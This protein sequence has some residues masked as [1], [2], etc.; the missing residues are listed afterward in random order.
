MSISC[1]LTAEAPPLFHALHRSYRFHLLK[2]PFFFFCLFIIC[3]SINVVGIVLRNNKKLFFVCLESHFTS[4]L[5]VD[6]ID[7]LSQCNV[8]SYYENLK[9]A[10]D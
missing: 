10:R 4:G 8:V 2:I 1:S 6:V 9:Y 5:R 3:T 7:G